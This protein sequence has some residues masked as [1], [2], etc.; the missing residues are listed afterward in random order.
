MIAQF[1]APR[2]W[3]FSAQRAD[4]ERVEEALL[5]LRG[6]GGSFDVHWVAAG[7]GGTLFEYRTGVRLR[8]HGYGY[9][10]RSP[11]SILTGSVTI[12]PTTRWVSSDYTPTFAWG[13]EVRQGWTNPQFHKRYQV[14][15]QGVAEGSRVVSSRLQ[16]LLLELPDVR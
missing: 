13:R 2:G 5:E 10:E 8:K 7:N 14:V 12:C 9:L 16:F 4:C 1:L 6:G 11:F 3:R 15:A